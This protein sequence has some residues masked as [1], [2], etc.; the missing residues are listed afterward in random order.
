MKT[1]MLDHAFRFVE[2]VVFYIGKENLRS[3]KAVEKI[4]GTRLTGDRHRELIRQNEEDY[5]YLISK[6]GWESRNR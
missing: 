5:T 2:H 6:S 1:L 3:Q 4:G